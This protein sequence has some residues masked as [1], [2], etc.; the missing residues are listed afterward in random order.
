MYVHILMF[1]HL[2]VSNWIGRQQ[3][4]PSLNVG[5]MKLV[6]TSYIFTKKIV[7]AKQINAFVSPTTL[8]RNVN[9]AKEIIGIHPP[10]P[11]SFITNV[12]IL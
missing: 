3:L 2:Q 10:Q 12:T 9:S 5:V 8:E 4:N 7:Q 6:Q 11:V 1:I